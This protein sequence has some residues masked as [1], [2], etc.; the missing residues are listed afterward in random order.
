MV[1]RQVLPGPPGEDTQVAVAEQVRPVLQVPLLKHAQF[2]LPGG[3][4]VPPLPQ[5]ELRV[6]AEPSTSAQNRLPNSIR[7]IRTFIS[8]SP[9]VQIIHSQL[10]SDRHPILGEVPV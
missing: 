2:A 4:L 6:K 8:S 5:P 9:F 1:E 10:S 3:Q 7:R